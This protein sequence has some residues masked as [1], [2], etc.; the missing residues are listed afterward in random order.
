MILDDGAWDNCGDQLYEAQMNP[1][2]FPSGLSALIRHARKECG[3][4]HFGV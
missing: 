2:K 1:A 4:S 3:L